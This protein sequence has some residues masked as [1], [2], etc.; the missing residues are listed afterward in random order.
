GGGGAS[1]PAALG[2]NA[3]AAYEA[4]GD[5]HAT[6]RP[7]DTVG[8]VD[9][10]QVELRLGTQPELTQRSVVRLVES[11]PGDWEVGPGERQAEACRQRVGNLYQFASVGGLLVVPVPV[12]AI[13]EVIAELDVR[14]HVPREPEQAL[15]DAAFDIAEPDREDAFQ[16]PELEV[17]V[18]LDGEL[19]R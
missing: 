9:Q 14:R 3:E 8:L 4:A 10:A 13:A 2:G 12:V 15:Q 7:L 6:E 1:A 17:R 11:L 5:L 18:P 19:V 16:H